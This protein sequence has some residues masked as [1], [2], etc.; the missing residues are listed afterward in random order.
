MRVLDVIPSLAP[1][2]GGPPE[3]ARQMALAFAKSGASLEVLCTDAP[4]ADWLSGFP[5]PVHATGQ[6]W[7]GRYSLSP[8]LWKWLRQNIHR[9]DGVV[10]QGIW[11]FP[12]FAVRLAARRAGKRYVIFPHGALDPWFREKYPL[13]HIK[14]YLYWPI[15]Y[16]VLRD[17]AAVLFT[18]SLEPDLAK[19]SFVPNHW[20]AVLFPQGIHDPSGNSEGE[21]ER[22]YSALPVLRGRRFLLCMARLH[23]KK[24]C[25]LLVDAFAQVAS[26][27]PD[28]DLVVAGPDQEGFQA[29][30]Q[31]VCIDRGI[32]QRV[33]W[34]G[35]IAGEVK[36]GALRAA[37]AFILPSHQEN[38]GLVLAESLAVGRPVLTTNKVNIWREILEDGAGLVEDDT[39]EGTLRLLRNWL[40]KTAADRAAMASRAYPCFASRFTMQRGA[41]TIQRLLEDLNGEDPCS[42]VRRSSGLNTVTTEPAKVR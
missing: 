41:E 15:Q 19:E 17:A 37:E 25:D 18:S 1:C 36:W 42:P 10:V 39:L 24:G 3:V 9:F 14:K 29:R 11:S 38:F 7:L 2:D 13:K 35:M 34:P 16:P 40:G 22:F 21:I 12:S 31:R 6:R 30:L 26:A 32:A 33:H 4:E 20:N 27:Y 5:C 23:V 28:V 8:R